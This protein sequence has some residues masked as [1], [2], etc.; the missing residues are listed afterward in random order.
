MQKHNYEKPAPLPKD[1]SDAGI[2]T[3]DFIRLYNTCQMDTFDILTDSETDSVPE[4]TV[5]QEI[6]MPNIPKSVA[7]TPTKK[8]KLSSISTS[9]TSPTETT[10]ANDVSLP[11]QQIR[12]GFENKI[13]NEPELVCITKGS[14]YLDKR[15]DTGINL[16]FHMKIAGKYYEYSIDNINMTTIN[17]RC[18]QRP[19]VDNSK[20]TKECYGRIT[21]MIRPDVLKTEKKDPKPKT[22]PKFK[23]SD[24]NVEADYFDVRNYTVKPHV[25]INQ[26]LKSCILKHSCKGHKFIRD[27]K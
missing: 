19:V 25:C 15:R 12:S 9:V 21:L 3:D 6:D 23:W 22:Q 13:S 24:S 11:L 17:I 7:Q 27:K 5:K 26:C 10:N 20:S 2:Q 1:I 14:Y 16:R 4:L 8:R 18:R